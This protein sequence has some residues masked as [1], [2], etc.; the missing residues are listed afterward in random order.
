MILIRF[1]KKYNFDGTIKEIMK[2]VNVSEDI[3]KKIDEKI[4]KI[5]SFKRGS[6][7][8]AELQGVKHFVEG[9]S[10]Q[11]LTGEE[12]ELVINYII[13]F[14]SSDKELSSIEI[15][16][17]LNEIFEKMN[18]KLQILRV[19]F[20]E[21]ENL[22]E[23]Y[24]ELFLL[25]KLDGSEENIVYSG[26]D[27]ELITL[28]KNMFI[29]KTIINKDG[30]KHYNLNIAEKKD[31]YIMNKDLLINRARQ[32]SFVTELLFIKK[33]AH[34]DVQITLPSFNITA[35]ITKDSFDFNVKVENIT[36]S[37]EDILQEQ[38]SADEHFNQVVQMISSLI[39]SNPEIVQYLEN[40]SGQFMGDAQKIFGDLSASM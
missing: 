13:D 7:L 19:A 35:S 1:L 3:L 32:K 9:Y 33:E 6:E 2:K 12:A 37:L 25:E 15:L 20:D 31:C 36:K 29:E 27:N 26:K 22:T 38:N 5:H 23:S 40:F 18:K 4:A 24:I 11:N 17:K 8:S 39:Q 21:N 30:Q 14:K 34:K 28:P 10:V 16:R